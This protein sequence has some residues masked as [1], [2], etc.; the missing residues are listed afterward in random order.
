MPSS[1]PRNTNSHYC[2]VCFE[3]TNRKFGMDNLG[4]KIKCPNC[5][6][7]VLI[8][9]PRRSSGRF[10]SMD[11]VRFRTRGVGGGA[12]SAREQEDEWNCQSWK[13]P[14]KTSARR[15]SRQI[16]SRF[17][18]KPDFDL[19]CEDAKEYRIT[20]FLPY[21]KSL[22]EIKCEVRGGELIIESLLSGFDFVQKFPLPE[23]IILSNFEVNFKNSVLN[24][25]F[26]KKERT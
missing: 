16:I 6:R 25:C 3:K 17:P 12:G 20:G 26:K 15:V 5:G 19:P 11:P 23:D 21:I 8:S 14:P 1:I 2:K 10:S 18:Q 7:E 9:K 22:D 24:V 4:N 13:I